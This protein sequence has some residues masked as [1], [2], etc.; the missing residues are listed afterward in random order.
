MLQGVFKAKEK[1]VPD[2]LKGL[3]ASDR[4]AVEEVKRKYRKNDG[5]PR[6]AQQSIPFE[7]ISSRRI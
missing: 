3:P 4:K 6:T 7:R 1:A 2:P 5:V